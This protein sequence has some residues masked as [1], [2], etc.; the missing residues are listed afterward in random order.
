MGVP[1]SW[2]QSRLALPQQPMVSRTSSSSKAWPVL[3]SLRWPKRVSE[4][5]PRVVFSTWRSRADEVSRGQP[6]G[7]L[8]SLARSDGAELGDTVGFGSHTSPS[9]PDLQFLVVDALVEAVQVHARSTP[10]AL[11]ID[12]LQWA[13]AATIHALARVVGDLHDQPVLFLLSRRPDPSSPEVDAA[14]QHLAS[15]GAEVIGLEGLSREAVAE[16]ARVSLGALPGGQLVTYLNA[17]EGNPFL[18]DEA[19]KAVRSTSIRTVGDFVELSAEDQLGLPHTAADMARL[20]LTGLTNQ[21]V[22]AIELC[23]IF[24]RE[25]ALIDIVDLA[26]TTPSAMW[27]DLQPGLDADVLLVVG[28]GLQFRHDLIRQAVYDQIPDPLRIALHRHAARTL[29]ARGAPPEVVAPHY[30]VLALP[31]DAEAINSL[32]SAADRVRYSAPATAATWLEIAREITPR[33]DVDTHLRIST[34]L[35]DAYFFSGRVDEAE[36][37]ARWVLAA[38][39]AEPAETTLRNTL[40]GILF[41]RGRHAEAAEEF[42][43]ISDQGSPDGADLAIVRVDA[44]LARMMAADLPAGASHAE[45]VLADESSSPAGLAFAHAVLG[46]VRALQGDLSTGSRETNRA[47]ATARGTADQSGHRNLP[48]FFAAQVQVWLDNHEEALAMVHEGP[49]CGRTARPWLARAA[50]SH[51]AGAFSYQARPPRRSQGCRRGWCCLRSGLRH[52]C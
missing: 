23:S 36:G 16:M 24:G 38:G 37:T 39:V 6:F 9:G 29:I 21:T 43:R 31:G 11:W 18:V 44:A 10:V 35:T 30:E 49:C 22:H 40:A 42:E 28:D 14:V 4:P 2:L 26:G 48:L 19:L 34:A 5:L 12:D 41:L 20:S 1:K 7:P 32:L 45:A 52:P 3:E 25:A 47:V 8:L 46:M 51:R 13:D 17:A 15:Q 27:R 50:F 33:D